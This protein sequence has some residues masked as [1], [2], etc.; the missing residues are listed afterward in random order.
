MSGDQSATRAAAESQR[1]RLVTV[2][3]SY[4]LANGLN[5]EPELVYRALYVPIV[6]GSDGPYLMGARSWRGHKV[7]I[8][9]DPNLFFF[10]FLVLMCES[11]SLLGGY[12]C[13][14]DADKSP[15]QY[16]EAVNLLARKL[17]GQS[18]KMDDTRLKDMVLREHY[19]DLHFMH[20]V[21]YEMQKL[22]LAKKNAGGAG[23][24][25]AEEPS[26]KKTKASRACYDWWENSMGHNF[27]EELQGQPN[28][29]GP[30]WTLPALDVEVA[31][32]A[33]PGLP[34]KEPYVG[35]RRVAKMGLMV[36]AVPSAQDPS[37]T[38][39]LVATIVIRD[40][41]INPGYFYTKL[42][43]NLDKR[44][45]FMQSRQRSGR[46]SGAFKEMFPNY[47]ALHYSDHPAGN[48]TTRN[49]YSQAV[50]QLDPHIVAREFGGSQERFLEQLDLLQD[51]PTHLYQVLRPQAAIETLVRAGGDARVLGNSQTWYDGQ[52]GLARFP[53]QART[54]KYSPS[55][56]FWWHPHDVGLCEQFFPHVDSAQDFLHGLCNEA[57]LNH[58]FATGA[59]ADN[60][61]AEGALA[62]A[63]SMVRT[64]LTN[65][66]RVSRES[67]LQTRLVDYDTPNE[68]VHAAADAKVVYNRLDQLFPSHYSDT[69]SDVQRLCKLHGPAWRAYMIPEVGAR[70]A[71]CE[72]YNKALNEAQQAMTQRFC[73]L[74][75]LDGDIAGLNISDGVK[76]VL[77][78]YRTN[79]RKLPHLSRDWV[80]FDGDLDPFGNTQVQQ[81][82]IFVH[83][84]RL[85]QPMI[86]M[87]SEG[88]LSAYDG[89][90]HKMSFNLLLMGRF[91]CGKSRH[92][93]ETP[94]DFSFIPGSVST[95]SQSSGKADQ[96]R[97]HVYDE[98]RLSDEC[99][100]F[101]VDRKAAEKDPDQASKA[102]LKMT[103]GQLTYRVFE[104][105]KLPNGESIRWS[106]D[107]CSDH[108][109]AIL[110]AS[111]AV[112]QDRAALSSRM[113]CWNMKQSSMS[114]DKLEG[115]MDPT[116]EADAKLWL[117][118]NQFLC[119]EARK[120][121]QTGAIL[122]NVQ[123][124]L[125]KSVAS[126]T[127]DFLRSWGVMP[128]GPSR[129]LDIV[130]P[131]LTQLVFKMGVR[132]A[133]DIPGAPNFHRPHS[134]EH[135]RE[136]QP[137]L[138]VTVSQIYWAMTACVSEFIEEDYG[139]VLRAM[140]LEAGCDFKRGESNYS[141]YETDC[142]QNVPW[143]ER[144]NEESSS[145]D[146][147]GD[148]KLINLN[149]LTLRGT[150]SQICERIAR[151]TVPAM[152]AEEVAS[153]LHRLEKHMVRPERGGY[154]EQPK[155]TFREWHV[156]DK[157]DLSKK[158]GPGCPPQY[159]GDLSRPT[160]RFDRQEDDVQSLGADV[161]IPLVDLSD[162]KSARTL[163]FMPNLAHKFDAQSLVH[164]LHE[165]TICGSTR[166]GK[167]LLGLPLR[168][169]TTCCQVSN[170]PQLFIDDF[171][172]HQDA[173]VGWTRNAM[174]EL[175]FSD[176][177]GRHVP[178]H[179]RPVS[180]TRG[181]VFNHG[182]ALA[183][184]EAAILTAAPLAPKS[185]GVDW[186]TSYRKGAAS[187]TKT[188][189]IIANLDEESAR[190]QHMACGRP[191]D[192]E[193]RT[194][195]WISRRIGPHNL[196]VDYPM[197]Q[198]AIRDRLEQ[199]WR[200]VQRNSSKTVVEAR[201]K[202]FDAIANMPRAERER[203][204]AAV[205][206]QRAAQQQPAPAASAPAAPAAAAASNWRSM[207]RK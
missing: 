99:P 33:V 191:L 49:T 124:D 115:H 12:Q 86:P 161:A 137:Y 113:L 190:R 79:R 97:K 106:S 64:L 109:S 142:D 102:K 30:D 68:F 80:T 24:Q 58:F 90:I 38:V 206:S 83:Y 8:H 121:A 104:F 65:N 127:I 50:Q 195:E 163:H 181:I 3:P 141:V 144:K 114:A 116:L 167:I 23:E 175:V 189:E 94:R 178:E 66:V 31:E 151:R 159:N 7:G 179:A 162:L 91:A 138:Y 158:R 166:P 26:S 139:I 169:D 149:Y 78:W 18:T 95:V 129:A 132:Y 117:H 89:A 171:V 44:H 199:G 57:N 70:V 53:Q 147:E 187:M 128:S 41:D 43:Q 93:I 168:D 27:C 28:P 96:T 59:F 85:L 77:T 10:K 11:A 32:A 203:F 84:A 46:P 9:P 25:V 177:E 34:P 40:S 13:L 45:E 111:N 67:V 60:A 182:A 73:V 157:S 15:K 135:I 176:P 194:P 54:W 101:M 200:A 198:Q 51:G 35:P 184:E 20:D 72:L 122:P 150:E 14:Y 140:M 36:T 61:D 112:A 185:D 56:A 69:L 180:R 131:L 108:K 4:L 92:G 1:P 154:R 52:L 29:G 2:P 172:E 186:R 155:A 6:L 81:L 125:F 100:A 74:F 205:A 19:V 133:F 152:T 55:A 146:K 21:D 174:G 63:F 156:R 196:D 87:L 105:I 193:V 170:M 16:G 145:G 148:N 62:D 107:I 110:M 76:A 48:N 165:A 37:V 118:I 207:I 192:E 123:L 130:T 173:L 42:L 126:R 88:L 75:Q 71:E 39:G 160:D 153:V 120:A 197:Q 202:N 201:N 164:A 103:A 47:D 98:I 134:P 119:V 143:R 82:F 136:I 5:S 204:L 183:E 22:R 17:V 188:R